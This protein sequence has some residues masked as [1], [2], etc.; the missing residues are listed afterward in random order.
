MRRR[1]GSAR[2]STTD[3]MGRGSVVGET[4]FV[5]VC[6]GE[7]SEEEI[8]ST[9]RQRETERAKTRKSFV[10]QKG[11]SCGSSEQARGRT[12]LDLGSSKPFDDHHRSATL[13]AESKIV[14]VMGAG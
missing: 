9:A 11:V 13:G 8:C 12:Q 3:D 6:D 1:A 10:L 14:R 7:K 2:G 4:S 5:R